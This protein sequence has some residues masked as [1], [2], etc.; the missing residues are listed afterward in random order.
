MLRAL[1]KPQDQRAFDQTAAKWEG[2][3]TPVYERN[4]AAA[5]FD[6][7][8]EQAY[9]LADEPFAVVAGKQSGDVFKLFT[10]SERDAIRELVQKAYP[11]TPQRAQGIAKIKSTLHAKMLTQYR[12]HGADLLKALGED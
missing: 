2:K 9:N 12:A 6:R 1:G 11:A 4:Q 5:K 7:Q 3:W 8:R 10:S